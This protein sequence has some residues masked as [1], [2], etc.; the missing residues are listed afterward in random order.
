MVWHRRLRHSVD[1]VSSHWCRGQSV[2]NA[3]QETKGNRHTSHEWLSEVWQPKRWPCPE[4]QP[5][6][7]ACRAAEVVCNV[8]TCTAVMDSFF[9]FTHRLVA[10]CG[11]FRPHTYTSKI[12]VVSEALDD[13]PC[14]RPSVSS[15]LLLQP[16]APEPH[17]PSVSPSVRVAPILQVFKRWLDKS[18]STRA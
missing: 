10:M 5:G 17:C 11:S 3:R 7:S 15:L 4:P 16:T 13:R 6:R 9:F 8:K 12:G 14:R 1:R 2:G 18:V